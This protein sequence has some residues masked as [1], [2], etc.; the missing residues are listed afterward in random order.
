MQLC[1]RAI[2]RADVAFHQFLVERCGN[3]KLASLVRNSRLL[4]TSILSLP[5]LEEKAAIPL[6]GGRHR[7][8]ME[9]LRRRDPDAAEEAL[10]GHMVHRALR[11]QK[12]E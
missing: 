4:T 6:V 10:R 11:G 5:P 12:A 7:G 3:R 8:L 9:V 1:R 2:S